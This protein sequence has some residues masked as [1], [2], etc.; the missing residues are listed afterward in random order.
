MKLQLTSIDHAPV[1]L[2]YWHTI[3]DDLGRPPAHRV[4][5]VLGIGRRTVYRYN[6]TGV[7]PRV[8]CLALFWLTTWG[9][10]AVHAQAVNDAR[11]ACGYAD[12]LRAEVQ[13]LEAN[14]GHLSRLSFG[15]SNDPLLGGLGG[16]PR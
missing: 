8:V 6:S 16:T 4:A 12:A 11:L 9:R 7:A 3:M 1:S 14:I 2:P 13:R 5:R 10:A 15:A